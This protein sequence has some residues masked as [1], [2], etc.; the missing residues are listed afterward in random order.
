MSITPVSGQLVNAGDA[1]ATP[2]QGDPQILIALAGTYTAATVVCETLAAGSPQWQALSVT[3]TDTGAVLAGTVGPLTGT[4]GGTG[5]VLRADGAGTAGAFTAVR[6]RLSVAPSPGQVTAEIATLPFPYQV[7]PQA[8][9]GTVTAASP[10]TAAMGD[11]QPL[12]TGMLQAVLLKYG[13]GL[14]VWRAD[15]GLG[16]GQ[17]AALV[18]DAEGRRQRELLMLMLGRIF[19][20]I[21]LG[22]NLNP[23]ELESLWDMDRVQELMG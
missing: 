16:P 2:L 5:L 10:T 8:V 4:G 19:H 7:G 12:A 23:E 20:A 6:V 22:S 15:G 21:C 18:G 1:L 3:R 9:S 14:D 11:Q 17:G 13:L